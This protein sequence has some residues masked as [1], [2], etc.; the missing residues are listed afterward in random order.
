M[1]KKRIYAM[2]AAVV[3]LAPLAI[4]LRTFSPAPLPMPE[5]SQGLCPRQPRRRKGWPSTLWWQ[6]SIIAFQHLVIAAARY[7]SG[8]TSPWPELW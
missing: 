2:V 6:V 4:V 7:S 5:P 3:I 1:S 8:A